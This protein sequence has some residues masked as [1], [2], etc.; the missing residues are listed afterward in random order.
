LVNDTIAILGVP[1]I[2]VIS[3]QIDIR[4]QVLLIALSFGITIGS[5]DLQICRFLNKNTIFILFFRKISSRASYHNINIYSKI[6]MNVCLV[7]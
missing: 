1:L 5:T 2:V 4:P 6:L 7:K 3:K